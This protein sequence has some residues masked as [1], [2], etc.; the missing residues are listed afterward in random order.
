MVRRPRIHLPECRIINHDPLSDASYSLFNIEHGCNN[1]YHA[2]NEI[3][4]H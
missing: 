2:N 4:E 1:D 3:N